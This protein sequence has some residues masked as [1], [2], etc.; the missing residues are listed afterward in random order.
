M[1][2]LT[3]NTRFILIGAALLTVLLAACDDMQD[4]ASPNVDG[5]EQTEDVAEGPNGGRLLLDGEFSLE[6]AIFETGVPPEYRAWASQA[7]EAVA[8]EQVDLR[9]T[10]TRLGDG[11]DNIQFEP[12]GEMLRGDTVIYEPHSF[13]VAVS[14]TYQGQRYQ[15]AYDSFEGR[16][17]IEPAVR[18][19][20]GIASEQAGPVVMEERVTVYGHINTNTDKVTH[21]SARF[22]GVIE[23]VHVGI[24]ERVEVGDALLEIESN[25][26]LNLYTVDSPASGLVTA[27]DA[28]AGEQT[29]GKELLTIIDTSSV[30]VDLAVF[31]ADRANIQAGMPVTIRTGDAGT[32]VTGTIAMILPQTQRNQAVT[33][34]LVLDNSDGKLIPGTWVSAD[35]RTGE[36][37]VPLAVRREALQSFRD[38]TVVY[39]QFGDEYEVRMLD[40]GRQS[41]DWAEVLGG[42][43]PGTRYVTQNSFILKA[44]VEKSGASHD[45]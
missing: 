21:I 12:R 35:I 13:A 32:S 43:T 2:K 8:P 27:R 26:G 18:D 1:R 37:D 42:L 11:I 28:N 20:L 10:L 14:A 19:A 39:A 40:L 22:D 15:W 41:G 31:P 29:D 5:A 17:R 34:R 7:G 6:L 45:H 30:W 44:D 4:M 25:E 16:T 23:Q 38:F 9:V 24:G 3:M 36:F 33:A